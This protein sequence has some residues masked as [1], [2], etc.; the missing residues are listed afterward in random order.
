M[1]RDEES[2]VVSASN[3]NVTEPAD[4]AQKYFTAEMKVP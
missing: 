3:L 2:C 4:H 1:L